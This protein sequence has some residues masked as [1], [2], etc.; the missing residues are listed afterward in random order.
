MKKLILTLLAVLS[1]GLVQAQDTVEV[2]L[3][4]PVT[5]AGTPAQ[6]QFDVYVRANNAGTFYGSL[7]VFLQFNQSDLGTSPAISAAIIPAG[8]LDAVSYP[9]ASSYIIRTP[10][11]SGNVFNL[12]ADNN[13]SIFAFSPGS[14]LF[15]LTHVEIPTTFT[16]YIQV[17]IDY[18]TSTIDPTQIDLLKDDA[19]PTPYDNGIYKSSTATVL[20]YGFDYGAST[21]SFG[22][23]PV[24]WL[25]FTAEKQSDSRIK[26][27]W[28]TATETNNDYFVV[29]RSVDG[30]LF[31]NIGQVDGAGT[32]SQANDYEFFDAN[33]PSSELFYRVMQVDL[34]GQTH[35]S[36]IA[37]VK[38]TGDDPAVSFFLYPGLVSDEVDIKAELLGEIVGTYHL[39]IVDQLGRTIFESDMDKETNRLE[40]PVRNLTEGIYYYTLRQGQDAIKHG[41]FLKVEK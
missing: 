7:G 36:S 26:L 41:R 3:R 27:D 23:L 22:S 28:A 4:N 21:L 15:G 5:I 20:S 38:I 19:P 30:E 29:Q 9:A 25:D 40:I 31:E 33:Y 1:L 8:L 37:S 6:L 32:T 10:S 24:E 14:P 18:P 2:E 17:T 34:S 11:K 35:F 16:P 12:T 13:G 39:L